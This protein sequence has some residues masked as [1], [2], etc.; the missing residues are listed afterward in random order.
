MYALYNIILSKKQG[1]SDALNNEN[2]SFSLV[3]IGVLEKW[4]GITWFCHNN[5]I[6]NK[7][8]SGKKAW[9]INFSLKLNCFQ[10]LLNKM[11]EVGMKFCEIP[12]YEFLKFKYQKKYE[13]A[14]K[15]DCV[16][17]IKCCKR[18][19]FWSCMFGTWLNTR[20]SYYWTVILWLWTLWTTFLLWQTSNFISKNYFQKFIFKRSW[21]FYLL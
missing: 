10:H 18:I 15:N 12:Q 14:F 16:S 17:I 19:V 7:N 1:K 2:S 8:W 3:S 6:I 21:I 11:A 4:S 5:S 9:R 20:Q 13:V